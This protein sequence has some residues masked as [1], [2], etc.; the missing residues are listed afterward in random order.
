MNKGQS[1]LRCA[2]GKGSPLKAIR[3]Y[4]VRLKRGLFRF[5]SWIGSPL[6]DA[7]VSYFV[8]LVLDR[9]LFQHRR[10]IIQTS[11]VVTI[12]RPGSGLDLMAYYL[13][14]AA[15]VLMASW[16]IK[17]LSKDQG[18]AIRSLIIM[19]AI[20]LVALSLSPLVIVPRVDGEMEIN[21]HVNDRNLNCYLFVRVVTLCDC[22]LQQPVP[23]IPDQD[24]NWR[25]G[26]NFGG[27][28][29]QRFE[30]IV[31]ASRTP[32]NPEPFSRPGRYSCTQIPSNTE[33]FVRIVKK[34]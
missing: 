6:F 1:I 4:F 22:W 10:E 17:R 31:I 29:G 24:G 7:I 14:V 12:N 25:A 33:R 16:Y 28:S 5:R 15:A 11:S 9:L 18:W 23:L 34:R 8:S 30:L 19:V 26:A 20:V 3:S 27:R 2:G 13:I 32:L 21:G